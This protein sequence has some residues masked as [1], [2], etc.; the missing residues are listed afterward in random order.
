MPP[1]W[2][3]ADAEALIFPPASAYAPM[4][5][6]SKERGKVEIRYRSESLNY[7][8]RCLN[9]AV[10]QEDTQEVIVPDSLPDV[11]EILETGGQTLIRGKDMHLSGV[12]VSG[13][14]E[15]TVLYRTEGAAWA[16]CRW[17]FPS[18]RR[19]PAPLRRKAAASWPP[20]AW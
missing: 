6:Q 1:D 9:T 4:T 15:L 3:S 18:R 8:E 14:S 17:I 10:T 20:S 13:L 12:A 7:Y 5:N 11:S 2:P 16:G 19:S